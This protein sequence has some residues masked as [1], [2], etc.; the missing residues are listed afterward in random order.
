MEIY[1]GRRWYFK[2]RQSF[3]DALSRSPSGNTDSRK[4]SEF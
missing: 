4:G 1:L 3:L 2:R